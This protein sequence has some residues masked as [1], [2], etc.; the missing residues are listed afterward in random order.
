MINYIRNTLGVDIKEQKCDIY[1]KLPLYLKNE[2]EYKQYKIEGV[3]CLFAKPV[4]FSLIAYKKH[5]FKLTELTKFNI[6][7]ELD[8][9]TP[10][11]RKAL[12]EEKIS[13]IVKDY[14]MYMPFL[15]ISLTQRFERKM[16]V[17]KFA[18]LT[19]LVF[20]YIF[21]NNVKLTAV[22]LAKRIDCTSMSVTRAYKELVDSGLFRCEADGRKKYIVPNYQGGKLL[23]MAEPFLI[24]PV[25]CVNYIK[26][27][28]NF[29]KMSVSG[30]YALGKKTML[31]VGDRDKSYAIFKREKI[32]ML[33]ITFILTFDRYDVVKMEKWSYNP[34]ILSKDGVVDDIS[35]ILSLAD[36]KDERV[37]ISIDELKEKYEW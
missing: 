24:N 7:L 32:S 9:I 12:I 19:Q 2:Y 29:E 27:D 14:Q 16:I 20:L 21:Y 4:E 23:K 18:P 33:D 5:L 22:E 1:T 35:L 8:S 31:A 3:E 28:K 11:Q 6:V 34:A 36:N 25:E 26:F 17:E 15:A 37:Q 30:I 10:Y 13:F